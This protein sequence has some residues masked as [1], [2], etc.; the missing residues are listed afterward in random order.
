ME[1]LIKKLEE[2]RDFAKA[3][4]KHTEEH[5]P[6]QFKIFNFY[7]RKLSE[8]IQIYRKPNC[9]KRERGI[10]KPTNKGG[11]NERK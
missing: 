5:H 11:K 6:E 9:I 7:C 10:I 3:R 8:I 4:M 1:E 2:L